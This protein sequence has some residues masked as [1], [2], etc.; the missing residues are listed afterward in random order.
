VLSQTRYVSLEAVTRRRSAATW[1][2][3]CVS[4]ARVRRFI[5]QSIFHFLSA[6]SALASV[7]WRRRL[8]F[9]CISL[10]FV[11]PAALWTLN[12]VTFDRIS[13]SPQLLLSGAAL[14]LFSSPNLFYPQP[15]AS[16]ATSGISFRHDFA[17]LAESHEVAALL[18]PVLFFITVPCQANLLQL[19]EER[20][21]AWP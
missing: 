6:L 19:V 17:I 2:L 10:L 12:H 15:G 3:A 14:H 16:L 1:Q 4:G 18:P 9:V 5:A 21:K 7:I 11:L 8:V 13:A 20:R